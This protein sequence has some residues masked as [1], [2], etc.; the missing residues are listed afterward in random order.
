MLGYGEF[1]PFESKIL[2]F[3]VY[4]DKVLL[5]MIDIRTL[6]AQESHPSRCDMAE[7]HKIE[8]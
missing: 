2:V 5:F 8:T 1:Y 6:L 3:V 4:R 7:R